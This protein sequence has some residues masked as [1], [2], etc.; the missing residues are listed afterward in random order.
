MVFSF[1]VSENAAETELS[2]WV[3]DITHL[4]ETSPDSDPWRCV[5]ETWV[6]K[7]E[8]PETPFWIKWFPIYLTGLLYDKCYYMWKCFTELYT[9]AVIPKPFY[10]HFGVLLTW[11]TTT[12]GSEEPQKSQA[13]KNILGICITLKYVQGRSIPQPKLQQ[14]TNLKARRNSQE[15]FY[16]TILCP[17]WKSPNLALFAQKP[18][19]DSFWKLSS[20]CNRGTRPSHVISK[21]PWPEAQCQLSRLIF[22]TPQPWNK[23]ER[24]LSAQI[25]FWSKYVNSDHE[26][27]CWNLKVRAT[28]PSN[29]CGQL[30]RAAS[31]K[32][33][34]P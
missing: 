32:S 21:K 9:K 18:L 1:S 27:N 2:S 26:W 30:S 14:T 24:H 7:S 29:P 12:F 33:P 4:S 22:I 13:Y 28:D 6:C 31:L 20:L 19:E 15:L 8:V 11:T 23:T 16:V 5:V 17:V 34:I 10:K 25:E 3:G